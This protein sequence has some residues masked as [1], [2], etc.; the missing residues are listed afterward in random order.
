VKSNLETAMFQGVIFCGLGVFPLASVFLH[1]IYY[2][3][4]TSSGLMIFSVLLLIVMKLSRPG[5]AA[6]NNRATQLTV[7]LKERPQR[8]YKVK[9][10]YFF[11]DK[12]TLYTL[13]EC[14]LM[15]I[16][17]TFLDPILTNRI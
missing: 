14:T 3:A 6:P 2:F 8:F 13:L 17:T 12:R 4:A 1:T 15:Q 16:F 9:H 10:S 11:K 7:Y 5:R